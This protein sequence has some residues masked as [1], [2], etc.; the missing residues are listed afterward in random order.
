M[1]PIGVLKWDTGETSP[2]TFYMVKNIGTVWGIFI[3][4]P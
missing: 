3:G 2:I 1:Q 4:G